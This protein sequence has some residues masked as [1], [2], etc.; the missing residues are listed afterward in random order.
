MKRIKFIV[1]SITFIGT[2]VG[3]ALMGLLGLHSWGLPISAAVFGVS[4]LVSLE[5]GKRLTWRYS[6]RYDT[7]TDRISAQ[8]EGLCDFIP[9]AVGTPFIAIAAIFVLVIVAIV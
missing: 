8:I 6:R 5:V 9:V 3:V 7:E 4:L 2:I 1:G